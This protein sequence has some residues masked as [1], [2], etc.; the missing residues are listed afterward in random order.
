[1]SPDKEEEAAMSACQAGQAA[2]AARLLEHISAVAAANDRNL[3]FSPLSIHVALALMSA[4]AAGDTLDE[5]LAFVGA[6]SRD[7]LAEFVGG[8]V[9][10]R[11]LADQSGVGG[12]S[13]SF[14]C[15]A[16]TDKRWPLRPAYVDTVVGK[17]KGNTWAVDFRNEPKESRQQINAWVAEATRNL[18]TEVLDPNDDNPYTVHVVANAIYFKGEWRNPFKKENTVDHEFRRFD[19][20]S[21]EVPFLQSWSDQYIACH[22]GFKVLKLPYEMMDEFTWNLYDTLPKFSMCIF[23]PSGDKGLQRVVEKIASSPEFLHDHL[24]TKSVPVGQFRLPKFKLAFERDIAPDLE[25]LGLKLP[26]DDEKANM[27]DMLLQGDSQGVKVSRVIHK[28]VI[29]MNEE[30]SEA[31]AVTLESDDDLGF[32]LYGDYDVPPIKLVNFVADHPFAFFIVEEESGSIVFAGHVL[33]PS[34]EQ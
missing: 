15:G 13:V 10:D 19:G 11:V 14:A 16:W 12:P 3:V 9:V 22:E 30:G 4:A 31:A 20:S 29:E 21:V 18:I 7:E 32:S 34:T 24:P 23:L 33:D 28:A 17:F 6:P 26:F 1:M 8:T 25:D 5:I 27:G 2:L